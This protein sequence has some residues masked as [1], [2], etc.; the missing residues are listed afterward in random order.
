MN[1]SATFTSI[2]TNVFISHI[3][4]E[5][6]SRAIRIVNDK[7]QDQSRDREL[8]SEQKEFLDRLKR[9]NDGLIVTKA[10]N[11]GFTTMCRAIVDEFSARGANC[12]VVVPRACQVSKYANYNANKTV[13]TIENFFRNSQ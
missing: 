8:Y 3:F 4:N 9:V 10:R 5:I 7:D 2:L 6:E 1:T 13:I 11:V 12:L